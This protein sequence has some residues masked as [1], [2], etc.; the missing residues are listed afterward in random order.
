[1][2]PGFH[3]SC[4]SPSN[5]PFYDTVHQNQRGRGLMC[6]ISRDKHRHCVCDRT[7]DTPKRAVG[8]SPKTSRCL[9]DTATGSSPVGGVWG[10]GQVFLRG[11]G[12][13]F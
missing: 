4:A 11:Q 3:Q 8:V 1:M 2:G 6:Q 12:K 9:C 5:I 13:S 10:I 7:R